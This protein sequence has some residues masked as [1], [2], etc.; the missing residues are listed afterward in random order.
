M[1]AR[2]TGAPCFIPRFELEGLYVGVELG[3]ELPPVISVSHVFVEPSPVE[4][5]VEGKLGWYAGDLAR[6]FCRE[7]AS[8]GVG[9]RVCVVRSRTELGE[10]EDE[11]RQ[12]NRDDTGDWRVRQN[13][14]CYTTE[15]SLTRLL[16][17]PPSQ[18]CR[19]GR[20]AP[21]PR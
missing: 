3:V 8:C 13:N 10:L 12:Y 7:D 4:L 17:R 16:L 9:F 14:N 21:G 11:A 18:R 5:V 19:P 20:I 2:R 15:R 6:P 1:P